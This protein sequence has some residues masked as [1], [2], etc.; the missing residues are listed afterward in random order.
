MVKRFLSVITKR[1]SGIHEAAILLGVFSILSQFLGLVR[2]RLLVHYIGPGPTLDVYY[3]A[4]KI[5]DLIFAFIGSLVTVTAIV[6][7]VVER[8]RDGGEE[9]T[10]KFIAELTTAFILVMGGVLLLAFIA[11]PA[12]AHI[13]APGFSDDQLNELT[14]ISRILL[15]SPL[16]FG[17]QNLF[18]SINQVFKKFFVFAASPVLYNIGIIIGILFFLPTLGLHGLA[19]GV[20]LGAVLYISVQLISAKTLG[21]PFQLT[22]TISLPQLLRVVKTALPRAMTFG[23][24]TLVIF[25]M[26]A[27]ASQIESGS[28]SIMTFAINI[29]TFPIGFIGSSYA[30]AAFPTLTELWVKGE[31]DRFFEV[32][33]TSCQHIAFWTLPLTALFIVLRAQIVRVIYGSSTL[34][35]NDTRLTA[36]LFALLSLGVVIQSIILVFVRVYYAT[37]STRK[38]FYLALATTTMTVAFAL[39]FLFIF[40]TSPNFVAYL[41]KLFRVSHVHGTQVLALGFGY[42]FGNILS[43]ILFLLLFAKDFG[44]AFLVPL[45]PTAIKSTLAALVAG[46]FSY[47]A[48]QILGGPLELSTFSG[49]LLQ[50]LAAGAVGTLAAIIFLWLVK[51]EELAAF[52]KALHSKFWK[53]EIVSPTPGTE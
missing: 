21:F 53:A 5:P 43:F 40:N 48:L 3:A 31:R 42:L 8:L 1:Y 10:R 15:I 7:F 32:V 16:L 13:V 29:Q 25:I 2:D 41:E 11:M 52:G 45:V 35:W 38:P 34:S 12:L 27:L 24:S 51:S 23:M 46:L 26:T 44:L 17:L 14:N 9:Q 30:I 37:G 33:R 47:G 39:L 22:Y 4:F 36:A 6:P 18:G 19:L 49:I 20:V 50:G 28:I